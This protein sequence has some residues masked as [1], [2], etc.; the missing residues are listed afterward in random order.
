L[1]SVGTIAVVPCRTKSTRLPQ[2][3]L[4]LIYGI[5]SIER[6]L[7]N[8]LSISGSSASVL[9]TSTNPEDDLL[10]ERT[11]S[12]A[13]DFM[14][15]SEDD[16]LER[17]LKAID[18]HRPE[19]VIRVTGD[20]PVVSFELAE[21][22]LESHSASGADVTYLQPGAAVGIGSE[23]YTAAALQRLRSL[24]PRTPHS[25]Y[26]ILYFLNN[27]GMF[28]LNAVPVPSF[29]CRDWRLTLDEQSDLELFERLFSELDVE[30]RAVTFREIVDFFA[31]HPDA[32]AMNAGNQ[33]RY[34]DDQAFVSFLKRVTT[35]SHSH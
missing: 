12:G 32:A 31:I 19:Y 23:I 9:I 34:R 4:R 26:L 13:A 5:P 10:A 1:K 2:K 6:C 22:L 16:V 15:G 11:V 8:T 20:C 3:A 24:M 18:R 33:V 17:I 28:H 35:I 7:L 14:R 27:P 25:E 29:Y 30:R 21:L